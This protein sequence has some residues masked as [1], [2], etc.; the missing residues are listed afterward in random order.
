MC[1]AVA[2]VMAQAV[3]VARERTPRGGWGCPA[4]RLDEIVP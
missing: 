4:N 2:I 1:A 3:G